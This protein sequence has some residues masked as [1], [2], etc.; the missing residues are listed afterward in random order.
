MNT[1]LE[2]SKADKFPDRSAYFSKSF[3]ILLVIQTYPVFLQILQV[4][5]IC[6]Q[7]IS[8]QVYLMYMKLHLMFSH[9]FKIK[10]LIDPD[11][12]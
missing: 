5:H 11:S 9:R 2:S 6:I 10:M 4:Q 1:H 8:S 7:W 12:L 3:T